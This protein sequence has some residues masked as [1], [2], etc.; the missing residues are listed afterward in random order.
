MSKRTSKKPVRRPPSENTLFEMKI[1][2][3]KRLNQRC[4][5]WWQFV[6]LSHS[7]GYTYGYEDQ[8][9]RQLNTNIR[10]FRYTKTWILETGSFREGEA[11]GV[12]RPK[13]YRRVY[14]PDE[15]PEEFVQRIQTHPEMDVC[16]GLHWLACDA[17]KDTGTGEFS[18]AVFGR[19]ATKQCAKPGARW[20]RSV[21]SRLRVVRDAVKQRNIHA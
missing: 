11:K 18:A 10:Q 20:K 5:Q 8:M 17:A 6:A 19:L 16:V 4:R 15:T 14:L 13:Q 2:A 3:D 12:H 9:A 21:T 7:K 1:R